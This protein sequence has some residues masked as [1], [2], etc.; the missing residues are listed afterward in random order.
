LA[1]GHKAVTQYLKPIGSRGGKARAAA[2][3]AEERI[4]LARKAGIVGG[5]ARAAVL[6]PEQRSN[7]A[8]KASQ[9]RWKKKA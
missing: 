8:R 1:D 5:H 3:T 7:I 6:T 2:L 4:I 9:A